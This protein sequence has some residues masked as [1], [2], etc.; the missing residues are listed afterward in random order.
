MTARRLLLTVA[1]AAAL[2]ALPLQAHAEDTRY[3]KCMDRAEETL[4]ECNK[5]S[6]DDTLCWSRFGYQK[7]WCTLRYIGDIV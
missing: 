1:T 6:F 5:S 7:L 4:N 2:V 3:D